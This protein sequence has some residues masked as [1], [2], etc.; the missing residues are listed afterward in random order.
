MGNYM[1]YDH[2]PPSYQCYIG[3]TSS[4]YEL[5]TYSKAITDPKWIEAKQAEIQALESNKTQEITDL[6]LEKK[7]IGCRWIYKVKYKSTSEV[8]KFKT[9]LVSNGYS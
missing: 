7:P 9:R 8:E 3:A 2:L 1:R 6:P 5:T 4:I